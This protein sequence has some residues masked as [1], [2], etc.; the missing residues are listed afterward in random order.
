MKKI[1]LV[2]IV[3]FIAL[4]AQA[5]L[6]PEYQNP[7]DLEVMVRF[8][9][10]HPRVLSSLQSIDFENHTVNFAPYC[11]AKFG[12][13]KI[14]RPSGWAGPAAPLEFK[15]SNCDVNEW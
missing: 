8:V 3:L 1:I 12:R 2:L 9:K 4:P 14:F 5:A 10:E 11:K 6:A 13:K 15:E 7:K